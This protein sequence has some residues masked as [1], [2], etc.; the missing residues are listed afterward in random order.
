MSKRDYIER[1]L[2]EG[3]EIGLNNQRI[4]PL[5]KNWCRHVIL[6]DLSAGMIAEMYQVPTNVKISCPH[7]T[8]A[9]SGMQLEA[10]ANDF[11]IQ[12]CNSCAYH[13]EIS[14]NNLGI[15]I[16]KKHKERETV[17]AEKAL[18]DK[19]KKA[20]L[21]AEADKLVGDEMAILGIT[22]LSVLN[23]VQLLE[24]ETNQQETA[25]KILEAAKLKPEYFTIAAVDY[26]SLFAET[27][28]GKALL[29]SVIAIQNYGLK[30][31][32]FALGNLQILIDENINPDETAA[33]IAHNFTDEEL[34]LQKD[35]LSKVLRNCFYIDPYHM[36]YRQDDAYKNSV[37]IFIRLE[38][39]DKTLF[40]EM[41]HDGI[42]VDNTLT[43]I[44]TN[45]FL[46]DICKTDAELVIPHLPQLVKSFDLTDDADGDSADYRI[47]QTLKVLYSFYP[48]EVIGEL[49]KQYPTL[50][51]LAQI[52]ILDFWER[53]L[54]DDEIF[55]LFEFKYS[56]SIVSDLLDMLL[57]KSIS[58]KI[59]L[60]LVDT[61]ADI[62]Q[63]RPELLSDKFESA[64]GYVITAIQKKLTFNWFKNELENSGKPTTT[65]NPLAG[66]SYAAI[67][68]EET[69]IGRKIGFAIKMTK[70]L[71]A[72]DP[73]RYN[74]QILASIKNLDSK[75]DGLLK[76]QLIDLLKASVK[77][78]VILSKLLPDIYSFL[79]DTESE[80][81]REIG[82][83]FAIHILDNFPEVVTQNLIATLKIFLKDQS[84]GVRGRAIEAYGI[85]LRKYPEENDTESLK[86][87]IDGLNNKYVFIQKSSVAISYDVFP[88]LDPMQKAFWEQCLINQEA[89]Y[90]KKEQYDY[91][92]QLVEQLLF[93]TKVEPEMYKMV[94]FKILLK[95]TEVKEYYTVTNFLEKLS[96]IA[97]QDGQF[98]EVWMKSALTFLRNTMP[99]PM[100]QEP[101]ERVNLVNQFYRVKPEVLI[102]N[103]KLFQSY[104]RSRVDN[105]YYKD[106][107][108]CFGIFAFFGFWNDCKIFITY[109]KSK[110]EKNASNA[111]AN[112][113][114]DMIERISAIEILVAD[115]S[116]SK[117]EIQILIK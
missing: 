54:K 13:E 84:V 25:A 106:I 50:S 6:T 52:E 1:S 86:S 90:F 105:F 104:A 4:I 81:V 21:K 73:D 94:V 53:L 117:N 14:N 78:Q 72:L 45:G 38:K 56:F 49:N 87:V 19:Q 93:Y 26:M 33:I 92:Q 101:T 88:F 46:A 59:E 23:L 51:E 44:N 11:I 113:L 20:I 17:L 5:I 89:Y 32:D 10:C 27:E 68:S 99:A 66:K 75:K 100:G 71:V 42:T 35:F 55:D 61:L 85:I 62:A 111:H 91:C 15:E 43:R 97:E 30:I 36:H 65:F 63:A 16:L 79:F 28:C 67:I 76:C 29:Q 114:I 2:T 22:K 116:L 96:Y 83:R 31:S 24:D 69:E 18:S 3:I 107:V 102:G 77:D 70:H 41:I 82:V 12:A 95:Y 103:M 7:T 110:V 34:P 8:V 60:K 108:D 57:A 48:E 47:K 112:D 64:F 39:L 74:P 9:W 115:K 80:E 109:C 98:Q 37:S 40:D 58:S